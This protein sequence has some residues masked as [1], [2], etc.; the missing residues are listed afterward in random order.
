[1][2]SKWIIYRET[3]GGEKFIRGKY[4]TKESAI[5]KCTQISLKNPKAKFVIEMER[6]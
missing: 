3:K 1:M 6:I 2:K 4:K 5:N